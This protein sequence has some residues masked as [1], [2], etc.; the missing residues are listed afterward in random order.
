MRSLTADHDQV[1]INGEGTPWT[2]PWF[3]FKSDATAFSLPG[4]AWA[5]GYAWSPDGNRVVTSHGYIDQVTEQN[6]GR[7][8]VWELRQ[9]PAFSLLP[10]KTIPLSEV[11]YGSMDNVRTVGDYLLRI[12]DDG[13]DV[14]KKGVAKPLWSLESD[15]D[16]ESSS[17]TI[18][19]DGGEAI[20]ITSPIHP[21]VDDQ[22]VPPT[23]LTIKRCSIDT[24]AELGV[25]KLSLEDI[26]FASGYALLPY[27]NPKDG[28]YALAG[29]NLLFSWNGTD[30]QPHPAPDVGPED[31]IG[32]GGHVAFVP[33]GSSIL[34][35]TQRKLMALSWPDLTITAGPRYHETIVS[36]VAISND[37]SRAVSSAGFG[38]GAGSNGYVQLWNLPNLTP[39]GSRLK[40]GAQ[41][42][43]VDI[44]HSGRAF[45][46]ST[47]SP[48]GSDIRVWDATTGLPL[49]NYL[50]PP[51][52]TG[53]SFL[54]FSNF[55]GG[56]ISTITA[57]GQ[58]DAFGDGS[59]FTR[60]P[61]PTEAVPS[62]FF[63][64]FLPFVTGRA[65]SAT[66]SIENIPAGELNHHYKE[67]QAKLDAAPADQDDVYL[68][69]T[70]WFFSNPSGRTVNPFADTTLD[71]LIENR[72]LA[73]LKDGKQP[74]SAV[75][76][77]CLDP[78]HPLLHL[79]LALNEENMEKKLHY[80]KYGYYRLSRPSNETTYGR[81]RW[82][83]QIRTAQKLLTILKQ[84]AA[85]QELDKILKGE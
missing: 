46:S 67:V 61:T 35:Y 79:Y 53:Q 81:D 56:P 82:H 52:G 71:A 85:V 40:H 55:E 50:V 25:C 28:H 19:P 83:E 11:D 65:I 59:Y 33:D 57:E 20:V 73:P 15:A 70:R 60:I 45:V 68:H 44:V 30:P 8:H 4:S 58:V 38:D 10:G 72:F 21:R 69:L 14:F 31:R 26:S 80:L 5:T 1:L 43:S 39:I 6:R 27:R 47:E 48:D 78:S 54:N 24:G 63:E 23:D 32:W 7:V 41:V 16:K 29:E 42:G 2:H 76:A 13:Y 37:G 3:N 17:L 64:H 51:P 62:W 22:P 84:P 36:D 9:T 18:F 74:T 66:G 77:Y 75:G 49:T 12:R 34:F